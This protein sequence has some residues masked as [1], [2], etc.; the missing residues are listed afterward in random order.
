MTEELFEVEVSFHFAGP[1]RLEDGRLL[2]FEWPMKILH[3]TD[4]GRTRQNGGC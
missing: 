1:I 3:S 4:G 2:A